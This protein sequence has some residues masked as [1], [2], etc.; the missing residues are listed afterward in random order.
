MKTYY[1]FILGCQMNYADANRLRRVFN[2]CGL[3]ESEEKSADLAVVVAC[4]VRQKPVHRIYGKIRNWQKVGKKI[5]LTGCILPA[6]QPK[7]F[8]KV[9]R[10]FPINQINQIPKWLKLI[11][12]SK[13]KNQNDNLKLKNNKNYLEIC[14]DFQIQKDGYYYLPIMTGCNNFC[15][16][17][18]VPYCRGRETSRPLKKIIDEAKKAIKNGTKRILLLGQNVNSYKIKNRRTKSDFVRLLEEIENLPRDFKFNFMTSHPKDLSQDLINFLAK[19]KKWTR[20][21]HLPLQSGSDQILK[22]MNRRYTR[23]QFLRL[24]SKLKIQIPNIIISTDI[25]V[26]FPGETKKDFDQ[27]LKALKI[28]KP[29]KVYVSQFSPRPGTAAAKLPDD[30]LPAEK[31]RRWKIIN[32]LFNITKNDI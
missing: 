30:V 15:S 21:L 29:Q 9:D 6:D 12:K 31:K 32:Q 5:W 11:Q 14:P 28:I 4:S 22:L 23:A 20:Q 2:S 18:A 10:I 24:I 13:I 7:L 25:I 19:S 8:E 3:K 1:L 16:Y 27:T 17:C 26:G